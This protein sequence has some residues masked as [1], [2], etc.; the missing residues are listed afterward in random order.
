MNMKWLED[1]F[2]KIEPKGKWSWLGSTYEAFHTF[3]FTP[4]TVTK[5]GSH[6]RDAVDMKRSIIIVV[7]ALI[8]AL[9]FGMWNIGYQ[10]YECVNA[11]MRDC[12]SS[13]ASATNTIT[14][15]HNYTILEC[16]WFGFL[17]MLPMIAVSY[18]VGLGIEFAFA[19]Y[20]HHEVN[21]GFLATGLLIPMIVPVTTPLWQLAIA[22]A[23]AVI[24]GKEVFGGSGMNFLNPALV[25]RAF[26]FFAYPTHMSGDA[27][28]IANDL[29]G[30]DAIA[31]ATPM[32]QL[33]TGAHPSA[34]ALD[35]LIGTIP[36]STCETSFIAIALGAI[37]LLMTGIASWRI[38]LSVFLGGGAMGLLFNA[39]GYNDYMQL[40][41]YYHFLMGGFAFGAVFMATDP[42]TAAQTN[43]GKWIYG[44]LIGAFAVL[45]R[46]CN[47]AYPEGMM[48]SILFMNCMAP[49]IDHCVVAR[50][51]KARESRLTRASRATRKEAHNG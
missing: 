6:I 23:F 10:H 25:A 22:V 2:E 11:L 45:L 14:Q 13:N 51:I 42:V 44:L 19:Q 41:F 33:A 31:G 48:L 12:V 39:I 43:T 5:S 21:E 9:L 34:S 28:W 46:V 26:L 16:W 32:G 30:S 24:I 20:R 50:N 47:P 1:W 17:R 4:K 8:P 38:M 15:L 36:G 7:I 37:L 18:I 29:W 40:P 27:V 35:M 49:L 3:A